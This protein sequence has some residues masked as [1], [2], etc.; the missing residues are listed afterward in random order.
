MNKSKEAT[1]RKYKGAQSRPSHSRKRSFGKKKPN[2]RSLVKQEKDDFLNIHGSRLKIE[3]PP[4]YYS[5]IGRKLPK[6]YQNQQSFFI[7]SVATSITNEQKPTEVDIQKQQQELEQKRLK[8]LKIQQEK[9]AQKK[10]EE[11][12]RKNQE[13]AAREKRYI[14]WVD[15]FE[16]INKNKLG[17]SQAWRVE[18]KYEYY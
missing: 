17:S 10:E 18:K 11:R 2:F 12:I 5:I 3:D 16:P 9:I 1:M 4:L 13:A 8:E 7:P 6:K 14:H 15:P